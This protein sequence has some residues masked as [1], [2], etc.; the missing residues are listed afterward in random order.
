MRGTGGRAA[1][2]G[3]HESGEGACLR[4]GGSETKKAAEE[5]LFFTRLT[6]FSGIRCIEGESMAQRYL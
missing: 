2:A 5:L 3:W 1:A 4:H 6:S